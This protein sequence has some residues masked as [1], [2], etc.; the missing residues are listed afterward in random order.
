MRD[1]AFFSSL[2][3]VLLHDH[4]DGGVRPSTLIEIADEIGYTLPCHDPD[5][6]TIWFFDSA[7]SGSLSRYLECFTHTTACMQRAED[8]HRIAYEWV[9][10][11]AEDH[12]IAAEARWAPEQ[13][14]QQGLTPDEA[15]RAVGEGLREGMAEANGRGKPIIARQVI[16]SLRHQNHSLQAAHWAVNHRPDL[17][18]GFDIAG[19][20]AGYPP[21]DH[22]EA[23]HFLTKHAMPYTIHGGEEGELSSLDAAVRICQARRIGHG[24]ATAQDIS[25]HDGDIVLGDL[26]RYIHNKG[27][28]LEVC[29]TSNVQTGVCD[30]IA[31]HP[32]GRLIDAGFNLSINTDN[33]LLGNTTLSKEYAL[34][35]Q[36]FS[37]SD[38]TMHSIARNAA[39]A[40]FADE[41]MRNALVAT[42]DSAWSHI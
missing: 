22:L 34:I 14:C 16:C 23:F 11:L 20:E 24:V 36:Y 21:T 18:S 3:K 6:L 31:S 17:V 29:P 42:I 27:I 41:K 35:S 4:L 28:H 7:T 9:L 25:E 37:L 2:P 33:R 1:E 40:F 32:I 38:E 10:D 8:L 19:P 5:Q 12:I 15:I 13:H 26:A 39:D 30:S